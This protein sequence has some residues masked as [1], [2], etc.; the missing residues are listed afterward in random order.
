MARL[1][2]L[3]FLAAILLLMTMA[4]STVPSMIRMGPDAVHS[5][6]VANDESIQS[7]G[8]SERHPMNEEIAAVEPFQKGSLWPGEN[9]QNMFFM[10]NKARTV[11]DIVTIMIVES[12]TASKEASTKVGRSSDISATATGLFGFETKQDARV[13]RVQSGNAAGTSNTSALDLANIL[14]ASTQNDFDGSGVTTRSGKLSGKMAAL[15]KEVLPNGNLRIEGKKMVQVNGE[16]QVMIL[17]GL[18]RPED[19]SSNNIVLST[20]IANARIYYSGV[21]VIADKQKPGWLAR[22]FDHAWPF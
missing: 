11:N 17:S 5:H 6:A 3:R 10:D 9:S 19:I 21:G 20:Y 22:L 2:A 13:S 15:V 4:C 12:S 16:E 14:K 7:A 18:I 8:S 1:P